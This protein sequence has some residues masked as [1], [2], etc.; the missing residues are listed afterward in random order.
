MPSTTSTVSPSVS[1]SSVVITPDSPT[2]STAR[3]DRLADCLVVAGG[4]RRDAHE[5]VD[6]ADRDGVVAQ[7]IDDDGHGALDAT[8]HPH[9]VGA[10]V[11]GAQSLADHRLGEHGGGR[12]AVTHQPVGL[13]GDFLDQLCAHVGE[14]VAQLD[15]PRDGHAVVGDRG[16]SGELLQDGIAAFWT[17]A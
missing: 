3:S 17:R 12:G 8:A 14:R 15:F 2:W 13:H 7:R 16:R 11:D 6:A 5:V 1:L 4:Q 10:G 9:R